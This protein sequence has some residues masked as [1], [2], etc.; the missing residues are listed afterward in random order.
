MLPT[1]MSS[2]FLEGKLPEFEAMV[3]FSSIEHGGLGGYGEAINPWSDLIT[4][5]R[6]WCVLKPKARALVGVPT[7][8]DRVEVIA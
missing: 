5:A 7:G 3:T 8:P 2:L 6:A 1:E 4:I